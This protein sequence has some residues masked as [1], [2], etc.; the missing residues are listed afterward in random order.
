M[1]PWGCRRLRSTGDGI[2]HARPFA[3]AE[4]IT[5]K[6]MP[7]LIAAAAF[8]AVPAIAEAQDAAPVAALKSEL[9]G[10][11]PGN[12][13]VRV[14]WRDGAVL[15]SFMPPFQEGFDLWYRP[16]VL[17]GRMR[18]LCPAPGDGIWHMLEPEQ[19]IVLEPTVGG[20]SMLEMRVSC[21]ELMRARS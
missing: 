8:C 19:D 3:A 16:E 9:A 11:V 2:T 14:R 15:A 18:D 21:R 1:A 4:E 6:W 20:K 7:M 17:L 5:M 13:Q 10:K 12:W